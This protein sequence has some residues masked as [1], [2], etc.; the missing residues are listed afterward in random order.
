MIDTD[1]TLLG[2]TRMIYITDD[3]DFYE[4][5]SYA[6]G[7]TGPH[8]LRLGRRHRRPELYGNWLARALGRSPS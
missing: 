2:Q 4:Q 6:L 7:D 3:A 1:S 5:D 8:A